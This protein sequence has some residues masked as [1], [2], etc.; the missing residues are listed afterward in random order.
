MTETIQPTGGRKAKTPPA[1][2]QIESAFA[3][4]TFEAP[5][6]FRDFAEKGLS[7]AKEGYERMKSAAEEAGSVMEN[8]YTSAA[9][10]TADYGLKLVEIARANSNA[11]FDY[12]TDLFGAK[13]LSEVIELSTSHARRQFET[14]T[15]Q[16]RE[17]AAL[18]QKVATDAAEPLKDGMTRVASKVS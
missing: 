15:A 13:S 2:A 1:A 14:V 12:A 3:T 8:T 6:A 11:A 9:K 7:Q 4:A 16:S 18:A 10:G 5:A 17:L